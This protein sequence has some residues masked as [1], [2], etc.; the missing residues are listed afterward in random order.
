MKTKEIILSVLL[1]ASAAVSFWAW[2]RIL[3]AP[4]LLSAI[5][6]YAV[7]FGFFILLIKNK[8][9][10]WG[11][12]SLSLAVSAL[13]FKPDVFYFSGLVLGIVFILYAAEIYSE[14]EKSNLKILLSPVIGRSLKTFFTALAVLLSFIYYGSIHKN[15]DPAKL[16]LPESA[17]E[18]TVKIMAPS[19]G[20]PPG[21]EKTISKTIYNLSLA[22]VKDYAGDYIGY[23]PVLA[24]V[25]YFF[26]LKAVSIMFYYAAI[27]LIYILLKLFIA[28]GLIKKDLIP[29]EK[30][31]L[32]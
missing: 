28:I 26:A 24:A 9:L 6:V 19:F 16:L 20:I 25:S 4:Y 2:P 31:I 14:E 32:T 29:A 15:T 17:F 11:A 30:E 22:R 23:I 3:G 10:F 8:W 5:L 7:I 12:P 1:A 27:F 13:F 18:A 21:E